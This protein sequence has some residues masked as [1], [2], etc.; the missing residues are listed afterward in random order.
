M[1]DYTIISDV[2]N[3]LVSRLRKKMCPEPIPTEHSIESS[4]PS[5]QDVDYILGVYLFDIKQEGEISTPP[6][7]KSGK[8]RLK[9]PPKP[10][11]LYYMIFINGSSQMGL[12]APDIQKILGKVAQ[13][14]AD[15][16]TVSPR[17]IQPWLDFAEPPIIFSSPKLTLEEKARIWQT[18]NKPYQVSLFYKAAP[19]LINSEIV[20]EATPV[21]EAEFNIRMEGEKD[22]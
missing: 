13:V 1:A 20:A 10:Y 21:V 9:R 17:E 19:V 5:A 18:I 7:I 6:M 14:V 12:K 16:E 11:T 2:T 22:A 15:T 3:F 8:T 4:S